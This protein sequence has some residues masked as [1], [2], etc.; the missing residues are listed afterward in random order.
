MQVWLVESVTDGI[1]SVRLQPV[2]TRGLAGDHVLVD[3]GLSS[4]D[5]VVVAG[6]QLLRAGQRVR[7]AD[8]K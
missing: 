6:A 3:S 7:V 8:P 1:G 5:V 4:G 2:K